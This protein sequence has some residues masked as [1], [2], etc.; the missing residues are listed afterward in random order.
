[1]HPSG[2]AIARLVGCI[3]PIDFSQHFQLPNELKG[4]GS[5]ATISPRAVS[6]CS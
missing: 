1:M 5:A 4:L 6:P 3:G 2:A